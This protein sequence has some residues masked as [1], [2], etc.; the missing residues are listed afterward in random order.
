MGRF[1]AL[2]NFYF[3]DGIVRAGEI[4][5]SDDASLIGSL[6]ASGRVEPA[7]A[8][9]ERRIGRPQPWTVPRTTSVSSR[10]ITTR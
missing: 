9:T 6:L 3:G 8:A 5:E 2:K 1:I 10:S 4:I 7:D